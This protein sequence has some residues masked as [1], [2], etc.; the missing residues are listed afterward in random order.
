MEAT[1]VEDYIRRVQDAFRIVRLLRV[2]LLRSYRGSAARGGAEWIERAQTRLNFARA[3][4]L[5]SDHRVRG[6]SIHSSKGLEWNNVALVQTADL[7]L[8]SQAGCPATTKK[9]ASLSSP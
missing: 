2:D 4:A 6:M 1:D 3:I 8:G 7:R 5:D 9:T